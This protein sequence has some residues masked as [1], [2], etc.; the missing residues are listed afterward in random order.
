MFMRTIELD[1][2]NICITQNRNSTEMME[3]K[4]SIT[5]GHNVIC[6]TKFTVKITFTTMYSIDILFIVALF[7]LLN[8]SLHRTCTRMI[9]IIM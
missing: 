3:N 6:C 8:I 5:Y 7:L 2:N 1:L 4:Q 9:D